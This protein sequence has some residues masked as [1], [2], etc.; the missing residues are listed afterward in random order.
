MGVMGRPKKPIDKDSFEKLCGYMC[1][2]SEI[3]GFFNCCED[4]I[5]RFCKEVYGTTFADI[6]KVLSAPRKN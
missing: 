2:L 3:A 5:E 6:Y 4:T 1:T